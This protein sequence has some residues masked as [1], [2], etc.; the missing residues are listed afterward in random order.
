MTEYAAHVLAVSR[1]A[2]PCWSGVIGQPCLRSKRGR[3][4][5]APSACAWF[6]RCSPPPTAATGLAAATCSGGLLAARAFF[7]FMC[8][9]SSV[10]LSI[11]G[12][13]GEVLFSSFRPSIRLVPI[14]VERQTRRVR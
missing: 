10:P 12:A 8:V 2:F 5:Y 13:I 1:G 3:R 7:A 4:M 11:V 9:T 14:Y 6:D